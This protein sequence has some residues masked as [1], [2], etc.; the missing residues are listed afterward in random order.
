MKL[1]KNL[2]HVSLF[3]NDI[4]ASIDYYQK[5]GFEVLFGLSE[6]EGDEPWD[7]YL[8]IAH[9][10]YLELQPVKANNPH[11]HP[12]K[13]VYY[14]NQTAWHFAL[15]TE[16][17]EE[18]IKELTKQGIDIWSNPEKAGSVT[19]IADVHHSDDGCLVAWLVDPD[20]TPIEVMEQVGM[21]KQRMYDPE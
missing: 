5:L 7:I 18:M 4:N 9:E 3:V 21:T 17:I 13:T 20:G 14:E 8:K 6:K 19:S 11:P 16:N 12:D 10:Q 15:Q 2:F 1:F